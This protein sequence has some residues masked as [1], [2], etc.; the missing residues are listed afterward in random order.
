MNDNDLVRKA[1]AELAAAERRI[2]DRDALIIAAG[3]LVDRLNA[4]LDALEAELGKSPGL[5]LKNVRQTS[6]ANP[7]FDS[8]KF[9]KGDAAKKDLAKARQAREIPTN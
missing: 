9:M 4:R 5:S 8:S 2:K 1:N 7:G 3:E 6:T